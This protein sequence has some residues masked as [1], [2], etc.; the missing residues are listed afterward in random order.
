MEYP[1]FKR[2]LP[3]V[4]YN[5]LKMLVFGITIG[6]SRNISLKSINDMEFLLSSFAD[7]FPYHERYIVHNIHS[8]KHFVKTV[9]D[10]DHLFNYCT[11]TYENIID[12]ITFRFL[13]LS[14]LFVRSEDVCQHLFTVLDDLVAS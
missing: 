5:Q 2:Y 1:I 10:F 13:L 3:N 7:N 9:N 11:F 8:V 6:E 4:H 14:N 12:R